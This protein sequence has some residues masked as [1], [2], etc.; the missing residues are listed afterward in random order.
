MAKIVD[1]ILIDQQ[2]FKKCHCKNC[3]SSD[4][5]LRL[6]TDNF[7][8][9]EYICNKGGNV[10]I[11]LYDDIVKV[12]GVDLSEFTNGLV[13]KK[14]PYVN[15]AT[16]AYVAAVNILAVEFLV[17]TNDR[18]KYTRYV[19]TLEALD[20]DKLEGLYCLLANM[21]NTSTLGAM[22]TKSYYDIQKGALLNFLEAGMVK[23][24]NCGKFASAEYYG[25]IK[26]VK[27][28]RCSCCANKFLIAEEK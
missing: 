8:R 12:D 20:T 18:E 9:S 25:S 23:C 6:S 4:L 1:G 15:K 24:P 7:S 17:K 26:N 14:H 27:Y 13:D 21:M 28:Y 22:I 3:G 19:K 2:K 10:D 16:E 5:I 11:L